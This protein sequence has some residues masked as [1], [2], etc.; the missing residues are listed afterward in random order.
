MVKRMVG[1]RIVEEGV[2][3]M[4][5]LVTVKKRWGKDEH[6]SESMI[7]VSLSESGILKIE[8]KVAEDN[9]WIRSYN[10]GA[11]TTVTSQQVPSRAKV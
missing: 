11:W 7:G 3:K 5:W 10:P 2:P 4:A 8:K 9:F 6:Y 1:R